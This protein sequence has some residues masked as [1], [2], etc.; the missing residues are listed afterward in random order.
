MYKP[1]GWT[2]VISHSYSYLPSPPLGD[3]V[4]YHNGWK[5]TTWDRDNDVALSNCALMHHGAWWYKNCYLANLNGK[6]RESKHSEVSGGALSGGHL[7][8][9]ALRKHLVGDVFPWS[10]RDC[11]GYPNSLNLEGKSLRKLIAPALLSSLDPE[12]L[13]SWP[14]DSCG[15]RYLRWHCIDF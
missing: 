5:F 10:R 13:R 9:L 1:S 8:S 14:S 12:D 2:T 3:A 7:F 15:Q 11:T 4:T 6:Y